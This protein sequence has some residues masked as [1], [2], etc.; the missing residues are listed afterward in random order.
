MDVDGQNEDIQHIIPSLN[1]FCSAQCVL[2]MLCITS[3][4]PDTFA[5]ISIIS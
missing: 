3:A 4:L 2:L 5:I 1:L